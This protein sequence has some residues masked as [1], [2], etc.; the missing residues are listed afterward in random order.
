MAQSAAAAARALHHRIWCESRATRC[1]IWT[2]LRVA[3]AASSWALGNSY[4]CWTTISSSA[5]T[6]ICWAKRHPAATIRWAVSAHILV[7]IVNTD[8]QIRIHMDALVA[9]LIC[10]YSYASR[11]IVNRKS[12]AQSKPTLGAIPA[13][14]T[15]LGW[16]GEKWKRC[17]ALA[18]S[19]VYCF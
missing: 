1:S 3:F 2:A 10:R 17:P 9:T 8:T 16:R 11:R 13:N 5:R 12:L 6:T 18:C 14:C 19:L 15:P 4:T 7:D